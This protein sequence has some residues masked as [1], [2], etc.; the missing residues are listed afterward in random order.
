MTDWTETPDDWPTYEALVAVARLL[1]NKVLSSYPK[2]RCQYDGRLDDLALGSLHE[3]LTRAAT[4]DN[5]RSYLYTV[6]LNRVRKENKWLGATAGP[7]QVAEVGDRSPT[8]EQLPFAPRVP[9][10][11][12]GLAAI[13]ASR[14][15][16]GKHI[17]Y[18]AVLLLE[19]RWRVV[20]EARAVGDRFPDCVEVVDV[21]LPWPGE[22]ARWQL[23]RRLQVPLGDIWAAWGDLSGPEVPGVELRASVFQGL[24]VRAESARQHVTRMTW[25]QWVRRAADWGTAHKSFDFVGLLGD[26]FQRY[27]ERN[28]HK[29][30]D[31]AKGKATEVETP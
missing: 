25:D 7:V 11:N 15:L 18:R 29:S 28:R 26:L 13:A 10:W 4:I 31:G 12:K 20:L 19:A 16:P 17:D 3:V 6:I 1:A 23:G 27:P 22:T 14:A 30:P 24:L 5:P 9:R 8:P 21:E 2:V